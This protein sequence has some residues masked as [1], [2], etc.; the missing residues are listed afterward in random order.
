VLAVTSYQ[1]CIRYS[2]VI[3]QVPVVADLLERQTTPFKVTFRRIAL[4][5]LPVPDGGDLNLSGC[6]ERRICSVGRSAQT[7]VPAASASGDGCVSSD[8]STPTVSVGSPSEPLLL[9]YSVDKA[10]PEPARGTGGLRP[11][12]QTQ[13][14]TPALQLTGRCMN[15]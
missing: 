1:H 2:G 12:S 13:C 11:H 10:A 7:P 15:A 9:V 14:G 8:H 4:A 6:T 3:R 5:A